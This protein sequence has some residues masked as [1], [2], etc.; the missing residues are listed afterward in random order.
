ML[1]NETIKKYKHIHMIGIGGTSMSGIAE[2][3]LNLGHIVTGSDLYKTSVTENLIKNGINVYYSHNANNI[4]GADLIVY[5]AAIK[6]DNPEIVAAQNQHI[7]ILERSE[8]LGEL[9]EMFSKTI[10]I[11]GT[12]GKTTTTSMISLCFLED[13]KDPSI[14]VGAEIS[15]LNSNYRVGNSDYF[16]IEACEYVESFLKFKPKT[17]IILNIEEDHLDYYTGIN[18]IK[19]TFTKFINLLPSF[20]GLAIVNGD[21]INCLD[22]SK[23]A[24]CKVVTYGINNTKADFTARNIT[25]DNDAFGEF[26]VYYKN[27]FY[28]H[29]KL[30]VPGIHNV[31]NALACIATCHEHKISK[32]AIELGLYKF[33]GACR[34]FQYKGTFNNICIFDDYAHHPTEISATL[35]V[36]NNKKFNKSWVIFQ[37]HTYT[38]VKAFLNDFANS[39]LASDN[40]IVTDI[41]AAREKD[42]GDISSK[43]LVN[44]IHELGKEAT[45]ISDFNDI[46]SFIKQNAKEDDVVLTLGAGTVTNIGPMLLEN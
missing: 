20:G 3:L 22:V 31:S 1:E 34:R 43:D 40:I 30:C 26:D 6:K 10:A 11:S 14:Q 25:F 35:N 24:K 21:D 38:R 45:Y 17:E 29:I 23:N 12:H 2:I 13:N 9:T 42:P 36:L 44:K 8:I 32:E 18:H 46:V 37:P 16:I 4:I 19:A 27:D 5:S 15:N 39:L 7:P 28:I 41:Y 33:T